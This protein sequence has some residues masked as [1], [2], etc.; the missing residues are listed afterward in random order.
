MLKI[1]D[2]ISYPNLVQ[3][4]S[5]IAKDNKVRKVLTNLNTA[6]KNGES[7]N[8]KYDYVIINDKPIDPNGPKATLG[9]G[10]GLGVGY[11]T[12]KEGDKYYL[13]CGAEGS[14][15]DFPA[16]NELQFK[17]MQFKYPILS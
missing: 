14:H 17:Y 15:S 12:K 4:K 5:Y 6:A 1:R 7:E 11:L 9:P 13:V 3:L 8:T 16:R 2:I 10:T